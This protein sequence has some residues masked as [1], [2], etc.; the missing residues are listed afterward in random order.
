MKKLLKSL[1]AVSQAVI[2][3]VCCVGIVF[4]TPYLWENVL[5]FGEFASVAC[6]IG[7]VGIFSWVYFKTV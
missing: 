1:S 3:G 4:T 7:A 5:G 6:T 2:W